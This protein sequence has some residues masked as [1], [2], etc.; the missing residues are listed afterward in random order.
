MNASQRFYAIWLFKLFAY[1]A[2]CICG[3]A[4][5]MWIYEKTA[6]FTLFSLSL[7]VTVLPNVILQPLAGGFVDASNKRMLFVGAKVAGLFVAVAALLLMLT[8]QLEVWHV[9][10]AGFLGTGFNAVFLLA[11]NSY[12]KETLPT[13]ELTRANS[14][15]TLMFSVSEISAPILGGLTFRTWGLTAPLVIQVVTYSVAIVGFGYFASNEGQ[16]RKARFAWSAIVPRVVWRDI[17]LGWRTIAKQT[18]LRR[19]MLFLVVHQLAFSVAYVLLAPLMLAH[20]DV[21]TYGLVLG[22]GAVG[23]LGMS[24]LLALRRLSLS[25]TTVVRGYAVI[26]GLVAVFVGL[27]TNVWLWAVAIFV[28]FAVQPVFGVAMQTEWMQVLD[29]EVLA[30]ASGVRNFFIHITSTVS[31]LLAPVLVDVAFD[32]MADA[33]H[34]H[35]WAVIPSGH[36]LEL[37]VLGLALVAVSRAGKYGGAPVEESITP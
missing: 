11:F 25:I 2:S 3:F 5:G 14:L 6:S 28:Y 15:V 21:D 36:A 31:F 23:A 35:G 16:Q 19:I 33:L 12:V 10:L 27:T 9:L 18:S 24:I 30:R 29:P 4:A 26:A 20:V 1:Q 8:E 34:T 32:P 7:V 17:V 37:I 22:V 13:S